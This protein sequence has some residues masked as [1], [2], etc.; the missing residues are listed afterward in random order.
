MLDITTN[1]VNGIAY[2]QFDLNR[3]NSIDMSF[4]QNTLDRLDELEADKNVKALILMGNDL[5]FCSGADLTAVSKYSEAECVR[6]FA[7]L[8]ELLIRVSC[9]SKPIVSMLTGHAIGGGLA[10]AMATDY[11]VAASTEKAKFGFPEYRLG[12][13]LTKVM[14]DLILSHTGIDLLC[15]ATGQYLNAQNA[16]KAGFIN[17][18]C[19]DDLKVRCAELC[20]SL[21][22]IPAVSFIKFKHH[23]KNR[24][25]E[26]VDGDSLLEYKA[27]YSEIHSYLNTL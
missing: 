17:E 19:N 7:K 20:E 10:L 14:R 5:S 3:Y 1:I 9:Y 24:L 27:I 25:L 26:T 8:D 21:L 4:V 13:S 2:Y 22:A 12:L 15:I 23:F 11:A 16:V 6:F 18:V